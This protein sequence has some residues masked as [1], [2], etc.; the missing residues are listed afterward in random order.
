MAKR[1]K[2]TH[3]MNIVSWMKNGLKI[4]PKIQFQ[5]LVSTFISYLQRAD[6]TTCQKDYLI[7]ITIS[8]INISY[9]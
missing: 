7:E 1:D 3:F 5:F 2:T 6:D 8:R 4:K 9:T